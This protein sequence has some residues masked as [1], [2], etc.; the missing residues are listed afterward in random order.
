MIK[1]ES[2]E[3]KY[4]KVVDNKLDSAIGGFTGDHCPKSSILG[5]SKSGYAY[6]L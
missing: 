6:Q 5:Q 3:R 4:S 1:L 2:D